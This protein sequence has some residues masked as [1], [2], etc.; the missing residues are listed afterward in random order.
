MASAELMI[1]YIRPLGCNCQEPKET[2]YNLS[3]FQQRPR[4]QPVADD[5]I[6]YGCVCVVNHVN[7]HWSDDF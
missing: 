4:P 7:A 3:N 2:N 5:N 1:T 6:V